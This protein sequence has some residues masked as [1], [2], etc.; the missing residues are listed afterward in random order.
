MTNKTDRK[1]NIKTQGA[2]GLTMNKKLRKKN[3]YEQTILFLFFIIYYLFL[4]IS[5]LPSNDLGEEPWS[6]G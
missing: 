3:D 5:N 2:K 4:S 6:S 1:L